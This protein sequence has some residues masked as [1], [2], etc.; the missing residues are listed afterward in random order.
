MDAP[1]PAC[2]GVPESE[3]EDTDIVNE[4]PPNNEAALVVKFSPPLFQRI[5]E[6][7]WDVHFKEFL[8]VI[9]HVHYFQS[10]DTKELC[11]LVVFASTPSTE[12]AMSVL[13]NTYLLGKHRLATCLELDPTFDLV[14]TDDLDVEESLKPDMFAFGTTE[15]M[16][17]VDCA[18]FLSEIKERRVACVKKNTD[19]LS[20]LKV[21][22]I[23]TKNIPL[24]AINKVLAQVKAEKEL[25]NSLIKESNLRKEVFL[26][27]LSEIEAELYHLDE[28]LRTNEEIQS[29]YARF[30][31]ECKRYKKAL[32][33]F[34]HRQDIVKVINDNQVCVLVG[35]TGSGKST[36]LVQYLYEAGYASNGLIVCTQPR[37][38]AAIS[39]AEHVSK[40]VDERVGDTY[41]YLVTKGKQSAN[42]KV[43]F[44][45][46][47]TL[48]NE[49]I[50]DPNLSKYSC[51]VID[52][53]HERSIHTDI[54]IAFIKRCLP[55]RPDL[56]VVITSATIDP[57]IFCAYFSG[58]IPVITVPGRTYPVE[59]TWG[60]SK[61][62]L[63]ET[64][65][66]TEAVTKVFDIHV[67]KRGHPG[68]ILV[69]LT[70][71]AEIEKACKLAHEMLKNEAVILPLHGKLQPEDQQKI[72]DEFPEKRKV[73]FSTN[74]AETSV[75]I[76]GIVYVID[77]GLS[78]E[79]CYD[80]QKNMN[81][82]EIRPISKSSADQRKGRAGRT[83]PGECYRLFSEEDYADMRDNSVPEIMRITLAFAVI[84]LYEFGIADIHS[85][86]FVESPDRKAL[87]EAIE[88]LK[89]LGAIEDG[90]LTT[91]GRK[92]ALLPLDPNLSKVLFDAISKGIGIEAAVA[93]S[94][95]TLS[96]RV[97][98]RP[99]NPES[100]EKSANT[101]LPFCQ[102]S[103]DQ[104]TYLHTYYQWSLQE[105][106]DQNKWCVSNFVN[107]KS[108]R[109][110]REIVRELSFILSDKCR[111]AIPRLAEIASL[112]RA[113]TLLPKI[114]FHAFLRNVCVHLGHNVVGYWS[115]RLPD[116]QLVI[117]RGSSLASLGS[118]PKYVV[119]E[120]TQKT[121]QHF[122]L[123]VL[124]V[125][126]E[127][128]QEALEAKKLPCHP[129]E[130]SLFHYF[131]VSSPESLTFKNLGPRLSQKLFHA[132]PH[133]RRRIVPEFSHFEVPPVFE[134][135]KDEGMMRVFAQMQYHDEISAKISAFVEKFRK[136][137]S[138]ETYKCGLTGNNDDVKMV[139]GQG[140]CI[141]S[142]L[143]PGEF[144]A[145]LVRGLD[146]RQISSAQH[147]LSSLG[148][149]NCNVLD[150]QR[151]IQ[152]FVKFE[153]PLVAARA[154]EY[155]FT[156]FTCPSVRIFSYREKQD[157]QFHLKV[158]WWRRQRK[159]LAYINFE[160]VFPPQYLSV[161]DPETGL[162]FVSL[163][164]SYKVSGIRG[165]MTE[166]LI[167]SRFLYY[168]PDFKGVNFSV[169][170][171]YSTPEFQETDQSI[172]IQ[173][174]N[175]DTFLSQC[176]PSNSYY[177]SLLQPRSSKNVLY[178]AFVY[179][180]DPTVCWKMFQHFQD[181]SDDL[182]DSD[183][184][185]DDFDFDSADA[186]GSAD[187]R[188]RPATV[189]KEPFRVE[190]SLSS[191]VRYTEHIFSVIK[192]SIDKISR[193]FSSPATKIE[194]KSDKWRNT[195]VKIT[196]NDNFISL[197]QIS[198]GIVQSSG[199]RS[200]HFY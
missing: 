155:H 65:Y 24:A 127:W 184:D 68:D 77:T 61:K 56:K 146:R 34:T 76:P 40:E 31:R 167:R 144:Q 59:V 112:D 172:S 10:K 78:K 7:S 154:F 113:E 116:E 16:P 21:A 188:H 1:T 52:E 117:H 169:V 120:R 183:D 89:F 15:A 101:K 197:S 191:S 44:M 186:V 55:N 81:S 136:E 104:M 53:A 28:S 45:T 17:V 171:L 6:V 182:L 149:C 38:L 36:Q 165:Y 73:V 47:H 159:D 134:H 153:D 50:A 3:G 41:G 51:L 137:L 105:Q 83:C 189:Y 129:A 166:E 194:V 115:E 11:V 97:F 57:A 71:P 79:L 95:S 187:S 98:F 178:R 198:R 148:A 30:V 181:G 62:S 69:F 4:D 143:M 164:K 48:L 103:G 27:L 20:K 177:I 193:Y 200:Y 140:G 180:S 46:D 123:Q 125:R 88:N 100:Q 109:M 67:S 107:A 70:C 82:L 118:V 72:F 93:V 74:V 147:E 132:Y 54:L 63:V 114:F 141:K 66:V 157:N 106:G 8:S 142:I 22:K 163:K 152:L 173:R 130:V 58:S 32:P 5:P 102:A 139:I 14:T 25:N 151:G 138:D 196:T 87:D 158:E 111:I 33:I 168:A 29:H 23:D 162:S 161:H 94:I 145:V 39:L 96:G 84:K 99:E 119:Y 90:K 64:D 18:F 35:E 126:E 185:D 42:T 9:K 49:C 124:P 19:E 75:T 179:F 80:P 133:D 13:D 43:L 135:S 86:E 131:R 128:I 176:A 122:L 195:Y 150:D 2:E 92:M 121:S 60:D 192:P 174:D 37:K 170:F 85:F 12:K 160:S 199:A 91:L 110:V 26:G 175:L 108:M 190:L 156:S